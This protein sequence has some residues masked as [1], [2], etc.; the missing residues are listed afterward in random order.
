MGWNGRTIEECSEAVNDVRVG[1]PRGV[2]WCKNEGVICSEGLKCIK[3]ILFFFA[4]KL[5][6]I[7]P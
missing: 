2:K 1:L 3:F 7:P 5:V 4:P 6:G